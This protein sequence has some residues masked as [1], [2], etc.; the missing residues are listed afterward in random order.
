MEE[1]QSF[2]LI[3]TTDIEEITCYRVGEQSVVYWEDIEQVF[4][5]VKHVKNGNV[6]ASMVR[7]SH[8]VRISP[9][10]I[11]HYP[12]VVLD[13]VLSTTAKHYP[14]VPRAN[15]SLAHVD[16]SVTNACTNSS[17]SPS[18]DASASPLPCD[19]TN[20]LTNTPVNAP[21]NAP[22]TAP[23]NGPANGPASPP[24]STPIDAPTHPST[25]APTDARADDP[26]VT[27]ALMRDPNRLRI[28]PHCIKHY[29]DVVLDVILSAAGHVH[30][31][32]PMATSSL[33][34]ANSRADTLTPNPP[35]DAP[36]DAPPDA[37][38][39][40]PTESPADAP[41]DALPANP[42]A[43]PSTNVLVD[44]PAGPPVTAPPNPFASAPI[45]PLVNPLSPTNAPIN[46]PNNPQTNSQLGPHIPSA[47]KDVLLANPP[48]SS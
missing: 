2:R 45:N 10:C 33:A 47:T 41:T 35:T 38:A 18:I 16:A 13:V 4:P 44:A 5:C 40:A 43:N 34:P 25:H 48:S 26:E 9:H 32:L 27:V 12:G 14:I 39:N 21:V 3:G 19:L 31:D 23:A 36:T 22:V 8:G 11:K 42:P 37:P 29:P 6:T 30:V 17:T 15:S 1:T 20:V 7:D 28:A 46:T 24:T